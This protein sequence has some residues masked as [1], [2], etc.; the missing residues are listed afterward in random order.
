[1]TDRQT[2]I[3]TAL[4]VVPPFADRGQLLAEIERRK[5]FI[6]Q[7]LRNA[8]L[9]FVCRPVDLIVATTARVLPSG[10]KAR[11]ATGARASASFSVRDS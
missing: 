3:A 11:P 7:C 2:E 6:K 10:D 4:Q 1:M 5:A 9:K 8:G